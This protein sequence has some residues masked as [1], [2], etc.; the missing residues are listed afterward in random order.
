MSGQFGACMCKNSRIKEVCARIEQIEYSF[1]C[2]D[3]MAPEADELRIE[4]E[5]LEEELEKL[6][7]E[8]LVLN[9]VKRNM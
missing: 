1:A 4:R 8:R 5:D 2:G 7:P 3:L 6:Q 9:N